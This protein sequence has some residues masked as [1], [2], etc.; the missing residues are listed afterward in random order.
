VAAE[1]VGVD[2]HRGAPDDPGRAQPPHALVHGGRR[3]RHLASQLGVRTARVVEQQTEDLPVDGVHHSMLTFLRP[4][5][6]RT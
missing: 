6:V 4:N 2:L 3:E 5:V 1:G